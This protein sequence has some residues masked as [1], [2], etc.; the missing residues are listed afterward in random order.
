MS[1]IEKLF[2]MLC[3]VLSASAYQLRTPAAVVPRRSAVRAGLFDDLIPKDLK[4][5]EL[6][7]LPD[8]FK[9]HIQFED[10][11]NTCNA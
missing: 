1:V 6:P 11:C 3:L 4:L 2:A 10:F 9:L 5:P 8:D 7:K